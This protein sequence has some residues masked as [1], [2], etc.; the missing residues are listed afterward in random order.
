MSRV[1]S[2]RG[3]DVRFNK[4]PCNYCGCTGGLSSDPDPTGTGLPGEFH[5]VRCRGCN[6]IRQNPRPTIDTINGY[7]PTD[8]QPYQAQ[9]PRQEAGWRTWDRDYGQH[10]RRRFI[11]AYIASGN[12]LDVGDRGFLNVMRQSGKWTV[13]GLEPNPHASDFARR[14]Y[15]LDVRTTG[16]DGLHEPDPAF[17]VVTLWNVLEHLHSPVDD[18]RTINRSLASGGA[19]CYQYP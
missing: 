9:S 10:K 5:L 15:G 4:R 17:D 11:E 1:V 8:Y 2:V 7:Y 16:L 18:L 6:L 3:V 19:A 14:A 12:L 13:T